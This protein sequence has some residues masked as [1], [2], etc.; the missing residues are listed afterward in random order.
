MLRSKKRII[1]NKAKEMKNYASYL[2]GI[3]LVA[4]AFYALYDSDDLQNELN[5]ETF[6]MNEASDERSYEHEPEIDYSEGVFANKINASDRVYASSEVDEP[7]FFG[8]AC[9][10]AL[11]KKECS[12]KNIRLYIDTHISEI[13]NQ[14]P[15]Q[16]F[17]ID[18]VAVIIDKYG[19]IEDVEILSP[20]RALDNYCVNNVR[21]LIKDMYPWMPALRN[22][23]AVSMRMII[24]IRIIA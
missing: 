1:I 17:C 2:I 10:D 16:R 4:A 19:F 18:K 23:E 6:L 11:S 9:N 24:P 12:E 15:N 21:E 20:K 14:F 5:R 7:A 8:R 22:K 3:L 13:M